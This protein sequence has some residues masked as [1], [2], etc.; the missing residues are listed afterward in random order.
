MDVTILDVE[1]EVR[2]AFDGGVFTASL[3][4]LEVSN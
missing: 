2:I 3:G 1:N 4:T